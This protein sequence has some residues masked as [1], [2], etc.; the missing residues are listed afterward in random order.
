MRKLEENTKINS[1][2]AKLIKRCAPAVIYELS[3]G[4]YIYGY[5]VHKVR[6]KPARIVKFVDGRVVEYPE[7]EVLA[8]NEEF[9]RYAWS[10]TKLENAL[11]KYDEL[12][13]DL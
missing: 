12:K 13:K 9:G 7:R 5:E 3:S 4:E 1:F 6:K 10:Y 11:R 8:S 2:E